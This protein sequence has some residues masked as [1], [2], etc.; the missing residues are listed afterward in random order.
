M[1]K[2]GFWSST[3]KPRSGGVTSKWATQFTA[4]LSKVEVKASARVQK[5]S[6]KCRIC[7][8]RNGSTEFSHK[9]WIWPSGFEHYITEHNV[10]PSRGFVAFITG[11]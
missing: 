3:N 11:Q 9:G 10:S 4:L 5:G 1:K 2:E 6:A 8:Q 7:N